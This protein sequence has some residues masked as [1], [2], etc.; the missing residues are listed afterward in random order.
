MPHRKL[1]PGSPMMAGPH[2]LPHLE[3]W[4]CHLDI[5]PASFFASS[6][7][8]L[9]EFGPAGLGT[10]SSTAN[11]PDGYCHHGRHT[12]VMCMRQ[13]QCHDTP[14]MSHQKNPDRPQVKAGLAPGRANHEHG[15]TPCAGARAPAGQ[16]SR[17][18]CMSHTFRAAGAVGEGRG[19]AGVY[20]SAGVWWRSAGP[21]QPPSPPALPAPAA[22]NVCDRDSS[23]GSCG[24]CYFPSACTSRA[25]AGRGG[26]PSGLSVLLDV[27]RPAGQNSI[28]I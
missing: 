25:Y 2:D 19:A 24:V 18:A 9:I 5:N 10:S 17:T 12:R 28:I 20:P 27:H 6:Y 26:S 11:R 4:H 13:A 15:E 23:G 3:Y 8:M 22:R 16:C 21:P 14:H 1:S 7:H